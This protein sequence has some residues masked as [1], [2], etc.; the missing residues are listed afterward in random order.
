MKRHV[1]AILIIVT[2][3]FNLAVAESYQA[4][5][6]DS[7]DYSQ[8]SANTISGGSV[9]GSVRFDT[10]ISSNRITNALVWKTPQSNPENIHPEDFYSSFVNCSDGQTLGGAVSTATVISNDYIPRIIQSNQA[11]IWTGSTHTFVNLHPDEFTQS[12]INGCWNNQQVGHVSMDSSFS[13]STNAAMWSSTVESFVNLHPDGYLSSAAFSIQGN[14][15]VGYGD[16]SEALALPRITHALIWEGTAQSVINLHPDGYVNSKAYDVWNNQQV[17][18][19]SVEADSTSK[20]P[21]SHAMLWSG[22]AESCIDLHPAVFQDSCAYAICNGKQVG[23]VR[24]DYSLYSGHASLWSGTADSFIDLHLLLPETYA[25]SKALDIDEYGNIAGIA[26]M[27]DGTQYAVIWTPIPEPAT[28]GFMSLGFW[29]LSS[30][31]KS[32]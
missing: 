16:L 30:R 7:G 24:S 29:L 15:Q 19:A 4:V 32:G 5:I 20:L 10:G 28:L 8:T 22:S 3:C 14:Q 25:S 1:F 26:Y 11:A 17:G 9:A 6:L 13:N 23:C 12:Q 21:I 18:A 2:V 31:K 27:D